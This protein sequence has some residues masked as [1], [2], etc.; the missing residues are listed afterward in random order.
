VLQY[1][2]CVFSCGFLLFVIVFMIINKILLAITK[3]VRI[4]MFIVKTNPG[5]FHDPL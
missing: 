2:A 1:L 4:F 3:I 5:A